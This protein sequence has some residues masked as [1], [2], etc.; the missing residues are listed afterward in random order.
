M[1]FLDGSCNLEYNV[2][3]KKNRSLNETN[4]RFYG[5]TDSNF[6]KNDQNANIGHRLSF[7]FGNSGYSERS[8]PNI[9]I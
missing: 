6:S 4:N 7:V 3:I 5:K 9:C 2:A 8:V 1:L